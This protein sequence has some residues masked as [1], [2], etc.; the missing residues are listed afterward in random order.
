MS[1]PKVQRKHATS[2]SPEPSHSTTPVSPLATLAIDTETTC[3]SAADALRAA[4]R[5]VAG[6]DLGLADDDGM[7]VLTARGLEARAGELE[8][9]G[10]RAL[11]ARGGQA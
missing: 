10:E 4:S 9:L 11:R 1:R 6:E 2:A 3:A 8:A 5:L 7:P